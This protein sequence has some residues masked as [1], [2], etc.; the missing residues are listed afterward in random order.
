MREMKIK[1]IVRPT[2]YLL[3]WLKFKRLTIPSSGRDVVDPKLAYTADANVKRKLHLWKLFWQLLKKLNT[4][5]ST[6]PSCSTTRYFPKRNQNIIHIMTPMWMSTAALL[7][8]AKY[9]GE[10]PQMPIRR[11][12]NRYIRKMNYPAV[13]GSELFMHATAHMDLRMIKLSDKNSFSTWQL[14]PDEGAQIPCT[15]PLSFMRYQ[16][17]GHALSPNIP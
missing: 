17:G 11:W 4:K 14:P 15:R 13:R 9:W 1:I 7:M 10:K 16:C 6:W 2:T 8:I 12:V 3:E 5:L